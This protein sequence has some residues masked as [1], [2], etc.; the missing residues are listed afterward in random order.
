MNRWHFLA[1]FNYDHFFITPALFFGS[2]PCADSRCDG[3]HR[4]LGMAW[5][6]V[7]LAVVFS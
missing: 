2:Q 6:C 5:L 1:R 3:Q 4:F 7:E